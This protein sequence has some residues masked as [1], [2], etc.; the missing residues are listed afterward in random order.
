VYFILVHYTP[1]II[2]PYPFISNP[3]FFNSFQYTSL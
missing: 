3:P 2:L 1:S